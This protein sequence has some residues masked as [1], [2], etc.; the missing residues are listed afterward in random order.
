MANTTISR[1]NIGS[2]APRWFRKF[3]KI[4]NHIENFVIGILLIMGYSNSSVVLLIIKLTTSFILET[5][6]TLLGNG[7]KYSSA[8]KFIGPY[9]PPTDN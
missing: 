8:N 7:E 6:E 9:E 2:P 5:L 3:K 1:N 4:F